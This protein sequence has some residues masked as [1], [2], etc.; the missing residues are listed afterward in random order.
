MS[1]IAGIF[2]RDGQPV[3]RALLESLA[4]SLASCAPDARAIWL[5]GPVGLAHAMLRT[6]R[7][8]AGEQNPV[9]FEGQFW[10]VADAR[11]DSREE[12]ISD[13]DRAGQKTSRS[14]SDSELIL[15][16]YAAWG[17]ACEIGRA[18]CRERV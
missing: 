5:D 12:L 13:V 2:H 14:L 16:A 10:I 11:L 18:S 1:G 15:H 3:E 6:T 9:S 8:A 17:T 7:E 4:D